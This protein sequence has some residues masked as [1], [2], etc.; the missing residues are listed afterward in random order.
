MPPPPPPVAIAEWL[1]RDRPPDNVYELLDVPLFEPDVT[2]LQQRIRSASRALLAWQNHA[3]PLT[4]QRAVRLQHELGRATALLAS[5]DRL[6]THHRQIAAALKS[7]YAAQCGDHP[8]LWDPERLAAWLCAEAKVHQSAAAAV[9]ERLIL[10]AADL[11]EVILLDEE[12]DQIPWTLDEDARTRR[13]I[14]N[15]ASDRRPRWRRRLD[16]VLFIVV[17]LLL[18]A[19]FLVFIYITSRQ[20]F[21]RGPGSPPPAPAS[22]DAGQQ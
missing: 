16:S 17:P 6:E 12:P 11:P 3:D 7:R 5:A 18:L 1:L 14:D 22:A 15:Y 8:A 20:R 10:G 19:A 4:A 2:Q 13:L 9:A 21:E